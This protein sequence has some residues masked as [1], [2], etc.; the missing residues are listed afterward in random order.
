[1]H[2]GNYL[3]NYQ[4]LT[5]DS[6][7]G[8]VSFLSDGRKQNF[9][10]LDPRYGPV[11]QGIPYSPEPGECIFERMHRVCGELVKSDDRMSRRKFQWVKLAGSG[12]LRKLKSSI[13]RHCAVDQ[14]LRHRGGG[15]VS[16]T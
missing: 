9:G 7:W 3:D 6:R 12:G 11:V 1:M 14:G 13:N 15:S 8:S 2:E 16:L 10:S 5:Q 4:A